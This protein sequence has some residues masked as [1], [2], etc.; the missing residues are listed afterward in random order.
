MPDPHVRLQSHLRRKIMIVVH[1]LTPARLAAESLKPTARTGILRLLLPLTALLLSLGLAACGGA[2]AA[3]PAAAAG[4][5]AGGL[6]VTL[7]Q[8][9]PNAIGIRSQL[10]IGTFRLEG[11]ANAVTAQ[12]AAQL[13]PPW[14]ML[15]ALSAGAASQVE[16]DAVLV[17]IQRAMTTDQLQ[18]IQAMR[19]TGDDNQALMQSLGITP[20]GTGPGTG[21]SGQGTTLDSSEKAT[22]QAEMAASGNQASGGIVLDKLIELLKSR[23]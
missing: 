8:D 21:Q 16:V 3:A 17:Q 4:T 5:G 18:A 10:L 22:R 11:T 14:Q 9:Y 13:T 23:Q 1:P 6:A 2:P 15:K 19:L 20:A 12:Q 7:T